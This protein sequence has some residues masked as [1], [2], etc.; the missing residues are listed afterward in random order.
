MRNNLVVI[1][2]VIMVSNLFFKPLKAETVFDSAGGYTR[3]EILF[4]KWGEGENE[5]GLKED[6][7]E[8]EYGENGISRVTPTGIKIDGNGNIYFED[9]VNW[10]AVK[11]NPENKVI[12]KFESNEGFLKILVDKEQDGLYILNSSDNTADIILTGKN[13]TR[14][15]DRN[16][17]DYLVK[18]NLKIKNKVLYSGKKKKVSFD[19]KDTTDIKLQAEDAIPEYDFNSKDAH[20]KFSINKSSNTIRFYNMKQAGAA[21]D[22]INHKIDFPLNYN[23]FI[24]IDKNKNIYY[25]FDNSV[26][27]QEDPV[28]YFV[29]KINPDLCEIEIIPMEMDDFTGY[30]PAPVEYVAVDINGNIYQ[31]LNKDDGVHVFCWSREK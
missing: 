30:M 6:D 7:V 14:K 15:I 5:A 12:E 28:K 20:I 22:E 10:K 13:R 1:M 23:G 8:N 11:Y 4:M 31:L 21:C 19:E 2:F 29:V 16:I 25:L 3:N 27:G 18:T 9:I 26:I 24:D 17:S